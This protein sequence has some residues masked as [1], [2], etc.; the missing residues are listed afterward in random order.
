MAAV[1]DVD[2]DKIVQLREEL[3]LS[4]R[5]ISRAVHWSSSAVRRV[6]I[7]RGIDLGPRG[8]NRRR[9]FKTEDITRVVFL[10]DVM[11]YSQDDIAKILGHSR[12]WVFNRVSRGTHPRPRGTAGS[13]LIKRRA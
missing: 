5:E 12:T 1:P 3:Y 4:I 2:I 13:R 11:G 7:A 8:G 9:T 10:H 6:L